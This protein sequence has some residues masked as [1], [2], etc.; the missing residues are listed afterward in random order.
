[1]LQYTGNTALIEAAQGGHH[2]ALRMLI[3]SGADVNA[4]DKVCLMLFGV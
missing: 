4:A 3:D 1:M 2:E